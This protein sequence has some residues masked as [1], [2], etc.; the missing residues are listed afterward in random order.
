MTT[1]IAR[2]T[3]ALAAAAA[4]VTA[5]APGVAAAKPAH[6]GT[7]TKTGIRKTAPARTTAR[8]TVNTRLGP[9]STTTNVHVEAGPT[10][11]PRTPAASSSTTERVAALHPGAAASSI[12]RIRCSGSAKGSTRSTASAP[13]SSQAPTAAAASS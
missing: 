13:A 7:N 12:S 9:I 3:T 1:H 8:T 11:P 2:I 6:V 4:L 5:L 10:G